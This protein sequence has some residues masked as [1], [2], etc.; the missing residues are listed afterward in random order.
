MADV[1]SFKLKI[2]KLSYQKS[3]DKFTEAINTLKTQQGEL[4]KRVDILKNEENFSGSYVEES[5][6]TAEDGM[7]RLQRAIEKIEAQRDAI[8]KQL[9][10]S[11]TEF[12]GTFSGQVASVKQSLPEL[13][14]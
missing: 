7:A 10:L 9:D 14:S 4:Q 11:E 1:Q 2:D 6:K 3:I 12:T 8:Q 13:F 5:I